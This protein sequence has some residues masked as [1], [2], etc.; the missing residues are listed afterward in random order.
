MSVEFICEE[1]TSCLNQY[2]VLIA[3]TKMTLKKQ[4]SA[5]EII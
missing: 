3:S 2:A 4:L 5:A 1:A